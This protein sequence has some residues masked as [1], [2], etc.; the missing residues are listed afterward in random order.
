[1]IP[2]LL[3]GASN[4][5]N[6]RRWLVVQT[7]PIGTADRAKQSQF[8]RSAGAAESEKRKTK[9]ICPVGPSDQPPPLAPPASPPPSRFCETKPI[10]P[11]APSGTRPGERGTWGKCAKQTQFT[12]GAAAA[13]PVSS[14][15]PSGLRPTSGRLCKQTQFP[16][17]AGRDGIWGTRNEACCT[18]K[19][20][21]C[22]SGD[23]RSREGK[24]CETKP[25]L[26]LRIQKGLRPT[27]RA[28]GAGCTNKPNLPA[29][30]EIESLTLV[31]RP[32]TMRRPC[33]PRDGL[34]LEHDGYLR[35]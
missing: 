30:A 33:R 5:A 28:C 25:I 21:S 15:R 14:P 12:A 3:S 19:P 13:T 1:M 35:W 18:N 31:G 4:K 29:G 22:R 7:N 2:R 27:A 26:R 10:R 34:R 32:D 24:S 16:G 11:A 9:P 20:N 8:Q 23:R 6:F 17:K